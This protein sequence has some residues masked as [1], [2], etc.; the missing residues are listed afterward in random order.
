M[1]FALIKFEKSYNL[2]VL[3]L[4]CI[5]W[6][7]LKSYIDKFYLLDHFEFAKVLWY[8]WI[9]NELLTIEG[10]WQ[11]Q[12][13]VW[14]PGIYFVHD[15][16]DNKIISTLILISSFLLSCDFIRFILSRKSMLLMMPLLFCSGF[17]EETA[18]NWLVID[19]K[20]ALRFMTG[21][22]RPKYIIYINLTMYDESLAM[23]KGMCPSLFE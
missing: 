23:Y 13:E 3:F 19:F 11:L 9:L 2:L 21:F 15:K 18:K 22:L 20:S 7:H 10:P 12:P 8:L 16:W 4:W 6:L 17:L 14:N 5:I 1:S